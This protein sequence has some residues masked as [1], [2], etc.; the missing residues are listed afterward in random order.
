MLVALAFYSGDEAITFKNLELMLAL[1][2]H[3]VEHKCLL[4]YEEGT[5]PDRCRELAKK[6]FLLGVHDFVQRLAPVKKWPEAPNYAWQ[7]TASE[8]FRKF[9]EPWMWLESD[10]IP[11]KEHWLD[12]L[13]KEYLMGGKPFMGHI[14][15]GMG[16]LTGNAIYPY[17]LATYDSES[18][19]CTN[20]CFDVVMKRN[21][22]DRG[23]VHQTNHLIQRVWNVDDDGC[24][25]NDPKYKAPTFPDWKTVESLVDFDA[26]LFHRCKDG[27][28]GDRIREQRNS[29][30]SFLN[31]WRAKKK[32][33]KE[34]SIRRTGAF[35]DSLAAAGVARKLVEKGYRV[36]F[37][38]SPVVMPL[39]KNVPDI[40]A[41]ANNGHCD[42]DLDG[43][44]ETHPERTKKHFAEIFC[45]SINR[46]HSIARIEPLNFAP[47]LKCEEKKRDRFIRAF[48]DKSR[49]W[50]GIAPRS[51]SFNVRTVPDK[52]WASVANYTMASCFWLGNHA[53]APNWLIDVKCK[54]IESVTTAISCM[55]LF[56][57]VDSGPLHIAAAL[58]VPAIA[59][60][61]SS[62]PE[63]HLSD[64]RDFIV[65]KP[66]LNCLNCQLHVCPFDAEKPPCQNIQPYVIA[67][68][69]IKK[70]DGLR[71]DNVS[72][73]ISIY[74]PKA[75]ILNR[76]LAA[77]L[78]QVSEVVVALDQAG[79][80]P[81][82]AMQHEKVRYI[83]SRQTDIGYGRKLN[84][85][86]RH[87][88]SKWILALNDDV[89]LEPDAVHKMLQVLKSDEKAAAVGHLLRYP[90]GTIQ[91]GGT[92][93]KAG[94]IGFG[95]IDHNKREPSIKTVVECENVTG[96]S[97]LMRRKAF[98]DVLGYDEG[99]HLYYEDADFCL[100]IRK[101]GWK[102]FYTP[103]AA[104]IHDEHSSTKIT[105][106]ISSVV[107]QSK[108]LFSKK[109]SHY[110]RHN[111]KNTF[112]D[113]SYLKS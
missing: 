102:I 61:Q 21:T 29:K 77:V 42:I 58:G 37:Q 50:V 34:I 71:T 82:G 51:N 44:Y 47:I 32:P 8:I 90:N 10:A 63:L 83:V 56:V 2:P 11:L 4:T 89:Y 22:V 97:V 33:V 25:T 17:N 19:L 46:Q 67:T 27:T 100:K 65:I 60:E 55:D 88:F 86:V 15:E 31:L 49:P 105:P 48:N 16:H 5:N 70:L 36:T 52:T 23:L 14:V 66:Y 20:A 106:Q 59:I 80:I 91:H 94:D 12:D 81:D 113:F 111:C 104:G 74:R 69:I 93:R 84:F 76:C 103:F 18:M 75:E 43:S 57:G 13:E 9:K 95:H 87:T 41:V 53:P 35:G 108:I 112:G 73:V 92:T 98:Y 68:A 109:W 99:F 45:E 38:S 79:K 101:N 7:Q 110:F 30:P 107:Q 72:C 26:C 85:G 1:E 62:S 78:P 54:D 96:A 28:L 64:Q 39:L 24:P 3:G 40:T 6:F